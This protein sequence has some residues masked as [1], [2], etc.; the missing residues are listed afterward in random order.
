LRPAFAGE[1]GSLP[2][3]IQPRLSQHAF[4]AAKHSA[5]GTGGCQSFARALGDQ[6]SLDLGE[7]AEQG[8]HDLGLQV[9]LSKMLLAAVATDA[10]RN[11]TERITEEIIAT[12][13]YVPPSARKQRSVSG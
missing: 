9:L 12:C 11:G 10:M 13:N 2:L 1:R 3:S 5:L 7:Q 4:R 8:N 6:V